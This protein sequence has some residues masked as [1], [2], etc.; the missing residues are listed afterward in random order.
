MRM[1][2]C[3]LANDREGHFVT[4]GEAMNAPGLVWSCASCGCRLVLHAGNCGEP[5]WFEHD[6]YS[7]AESV[8]MN[9][10]HLDPQVKEGARQRKLR[11]MIGDLDVP[12]AVRQ[13]HCVWCGDHYSGEKQCPR[14]GIGIY[15]I[16]A[17][18]GQANYV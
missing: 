3:H 6:Q 8:L 10:A 12:V 17:E 11:R 7:V 1:L 13:W 14:C 9:C 15:S 5:A 4:A 2:K 16:Q 18:N